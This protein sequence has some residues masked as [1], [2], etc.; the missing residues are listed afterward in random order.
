FGKTWSIVTSVE[1]VGAKDWKADG[2][3]NARIPLLPGERVTTAAVP[4]EKESVVITLEREVDNFSYQSTLEQRDVVSLVAASNPKLADQR[5]NEQWTVDCSPIWHCELDGL[6]PVT[7]Q[8]DGHWS[9]TFVPWPGERVDIRLGRPDAAAGVSTTIDAVDLRLSPGVRLM[10]A[11]LSARVRTTTQHN[12]ALKLPQGIVLSEVVLDGTPQALQVE[13]DTVTVQLQPGQHQVDV[14]WQEQGGIRAFLRSSRV[15]LD[16]KL[17]NAKVTI[18]LPADRW[19]LLAGGEGWGPAVLFWGYLALILMLAPLLARLPGSPLSTG[20]WAI[21]G[22]GFTQVPVL[23]AGLVVA[24][25]FL[26]GHADNLR[27]RTP[28]GH[29]AFQLTLVF[30]T[31]IFVTC[32]FGAV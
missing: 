18:A 2:A 21:L 29:N 13:Q 26:F 25:F 3:V 9:P 5:F 28:F 31:G 23:V 11:R 4:V 16:Q 30:A 32:L 6:A 17:V 14:S 10:K 1:R 15:E 19:L 20:Q 8:R 12:L 22:L 27:P 24:W 7:R